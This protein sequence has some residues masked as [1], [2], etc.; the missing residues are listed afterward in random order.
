MSKCIKLENSTITHLL[1]HLTPKQWKSA[2][3]DTE[4]DNELMNELIKIQERKYKFELE[5]A[6]ER[7][8]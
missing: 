2:K 6:I 3:E 7:Q 4:T 5:K 1:G 8:E